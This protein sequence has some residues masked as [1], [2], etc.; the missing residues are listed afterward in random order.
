MEHFRSSCCCSSSR[1]FKLLILLILASF[2]LSFA[3]EARPIKDA[4]EMVAGGGLMAAEMDDWLS[5]LLLGEAKNQGPSDGGGHG[6][7]ELDE[8][9]EGPS[10]GGGH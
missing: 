4:G 7:V 6:P 9:E 3:A 2:L 10:P 5:G 1:V 8:A